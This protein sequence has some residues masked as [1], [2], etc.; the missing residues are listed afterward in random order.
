MIAPHALV[1]DAG[2]L[3]TDSTNYFG[4][5][6]GLKVIELRK[7]EYACT[8]RMPPNSFGG[9]KVGANLD[10]DK[11]NRLHEVIKKAVE[12]DKRIA[13]K[14]E[15]LEEF[16]LDQLPWWRYIYIYVHLS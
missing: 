1:L 13:G 12:K 15:I 10:K 5:V 9:G 4:K 11:K 2:K 8:N 7:D 6:E 3:V 16:Q 14:N